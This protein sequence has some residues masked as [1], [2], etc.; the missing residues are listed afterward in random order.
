MKSISKATAS[1][2][3]LEWKSIC[4]VPVS[5]C[6]RWRSVGSPS[7]RC[8]RISACFADGVLRGQ[9]GLQKLNKLS[10]RITCNCDPGMN[11]EKLTWPHRAL[12]AYYAFSAS[13]MS[14]SPSSHYH[15]H[16]SLLPYPAFSLSPLALISPTCS[17]GGS[18]GYDRSCLHFRKH[19]LSTWE[20]IVGKVLTS[21]SELEVL[22]DMT[23]S[24]HHRKKHWKYLKNKWRGLM[25]MMRWRGCPL[26]D[27]LHLNVVIDGDKPVLAY[28]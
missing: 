3:C 10:F 1:E 5:R 16:A 25:T 12:T 6:N 21:L 4:F 17:H 22:E 8:A 11:G 26:C 19:S 13:F 9:R 2:P 7:R 14:S 28:I 23:S 27:C 24:L 20:A 15:H 18:S